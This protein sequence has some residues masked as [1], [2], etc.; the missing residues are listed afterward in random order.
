MQKRKSLAMNLDSILRPQ[1]DRAELI[2]SELPAIS[3]NTKQAD[4]KKL[5][6]QFESKLKFKTGSE[7]MKEIPASEPRIK[8]TMKRDETGSFVIQKKSG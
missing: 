7:T 2:D 1:S 5:L 8:P 4:F 6:P 3:I